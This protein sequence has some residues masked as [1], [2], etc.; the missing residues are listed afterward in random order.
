MFISTYTV[1]ASDLSAINNK[2]SGENLETHV[3]RERTPSPGRAGKGA[4]DI[5]T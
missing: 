3:T 5:S 1:L 2:Y 4:P